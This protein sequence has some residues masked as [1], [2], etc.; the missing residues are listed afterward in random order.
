MYE[1]VKQLKTVYPQPAIEI[2][3]NEI[4]SGKV[5]NVQAIHHELFHIID[6]TQL[7]LMPKIEG[8]LKMLPTI[9]H[10]GSLLVLETHEGRFRAMHFPVFMGEKLYTGYLK[11]FLQDT[12]ELIHVPENFEFL[13][14][15][16]NI[17]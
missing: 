11:I 5:T 12:G 14:C 13:R 4:R 6:S 15:L 3:L 8:P 7:H 9:P 2:I 16:R 1:I 17:S 10:S